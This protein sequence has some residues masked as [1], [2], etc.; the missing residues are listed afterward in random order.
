[1]QQI[2]K[3]DKPRLTFFLSSSDDKKIIQIINHS[4]KTTASHHAS[5]IVRATVEN[6][7][8]AQ[9]TETKTVVHVIIGLFFAF[10]SV[11]GTRT[12]LALMLSRGTVNTNVLV[13]T[14]LLI[15]ATGWVK[16]PAKTEF[17]IS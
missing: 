10:L 2:D 3:G 15:W 4:T 6:E 9:E 13:M 16:V 8:C 5:N 7:R 1:M 17:L 14:P 11:R 12:T